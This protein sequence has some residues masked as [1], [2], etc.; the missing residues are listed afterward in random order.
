LTWL[1]SRGAVPLSRGRLGETIGIDR[2]RPREL[3]ITAEERFGGYAKRIRAKFGT[4]A[5][6]D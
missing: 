6:Y 5:S 1:T 2:P 3:D 4:K